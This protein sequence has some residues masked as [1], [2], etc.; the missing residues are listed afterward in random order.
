MNGMAGEG[1]VTIE[2]MEMML[3]EI[4]LEL[5]EVFYKDLNGGILLLPE[6]RMHPKGVGN[7]LYIMGEYHRNSAQGRF[8]V[9]YYG[10]FSNVYGH[11]PPEQLKERLASTLKHEFQHH[12][13]SLAGD[14]SLEKKDEQDMARYMNR[15]VKRDHR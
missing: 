5:P 9:I 4:A 1:M 13:E 7:D 11:L 2:E 14:R 8:I 10:S 15:K 12:L 3:D 6:V